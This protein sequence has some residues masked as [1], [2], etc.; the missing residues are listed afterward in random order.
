MEG[1]EEEDEEEVGGEEKTIRTMYPVA[2]LSHSNVKSSFPPPRPRAHTLGISVPRT[3]QLLPRPMSR[4][5]PLLGTRLEMRCRLRCFYSDTSAATPPREITGATYRTISRLAIVPFW[6]AT[7]AAMMGMV[8][9][10]PPLPHTHS[11]GAHYVHK[12]AGTL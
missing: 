10:S 4:A 1:E 11:P 3:R 2:A 7:L 9:A 5:S 12:W 8:P 6:L